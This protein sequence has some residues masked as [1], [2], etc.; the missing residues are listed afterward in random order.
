MQFYAP[1]LFESLASGSLGGLLN[2]VIIDCIN[3]L[4]TFIAVGFVDKW[5]RRALLIGTAAWMFVTQIIVAV[6]LAIEFGKYGSELPGSISVGVLVIVCA[7]ICG[8]AAG[9]GP[10][11]WLYPA[12]EDELLLD[13]HRDTESQKYSLWQLHSLLCKL[14]RRSARRVP[15]HFFPLTEVS[16][17]CPAA[18]RSIGWFQFE[19]PV[20]CC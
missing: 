19:E 2:T 16:E 20:G 4:A 12:G 3:V 11:G 1:I 14:L 15:R 6:V 17:G 8:H 10:I 18:S 9:W 7:Y 13:V 5:G